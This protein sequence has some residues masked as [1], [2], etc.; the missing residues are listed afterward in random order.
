MTLAMKFVFAFM[1]DSTDKCSQRRRYNTGA[2]ARTALRNST[3]SR[4][5]LLSDL[6]LLPSPTR[7]LRRAV[8]FRDLNIAGIVLT[9]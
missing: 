9:V 4:S 8:L 7:S 2:V 6:A 3:T 5:E 1:L